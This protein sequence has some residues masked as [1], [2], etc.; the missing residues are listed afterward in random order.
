MSIEDHEE[1]VDIVFKIIEDHNL[2]CNA[3]KYQLRAKNFKSLDH[4]INVLDDG[5]TFQTT[6]EYKTAIKNFSTPW[7]PETA[8]KDTWNGGMDQKLG[9]QL[10]Q[11]SEAT[12]GQSESSAEVKL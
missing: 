5:V 11:K 9:A 1:L 4:G 2:K 12:S 6:D 8:T 7:D 10:L 3:Q